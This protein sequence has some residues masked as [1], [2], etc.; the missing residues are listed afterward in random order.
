MEI[1]SV[2][3]ILDHASKKYFKEERGRWVFRGHANSK[4]DLKPSVGRGKHTSKSREKYEESLFAIFCREAVGFISSFPADDWERLSLA[5][6]HGLPTRLLDWTNNILAA[7][8]FAVEA[9]PDADGAVFALH[10][11]NKASGDQISGSPFRISKP[12]K[13]YPNLVTPRIRAQEGLFVV[14]SDLEM[15][16]DQNLRSDW[17]IEKL[18][19]PQAKK[20][21]IRYALFR[22]GIHSSSIY[23]DI[24][25]LSARLQ[26]QHSVTSPFIESS[27]LP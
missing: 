2:Q 14:C 18:L 11:I 19:I 4:Y 15:P 9:H 12:T 5:Q 24:G 1:T 13:Y 26:W 6:H 25:G 22:L 10:A 20:E 23:P 17:Q 8:Y 7:L 16:L 21:Q 27:D 3:E